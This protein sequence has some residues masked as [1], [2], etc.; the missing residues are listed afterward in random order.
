MGLIRG[1]H[2][3]RYADD[4]QLAMPWFGTTSPCR[5]A[6]AGYGA[7]THSFG[8]TGSKQHGDQLMSGL[9]R[10]GGSEPGATADSSTRQRSDAPGNAPP[11]RA[12]RDLE[13]RQAMASSRLRQPT[14]MPARRARTTAKDV[15]AALALPASGPASSQP[16]RPPLPNLHRLP[17][18]A[19]MVYDIG[20]VDTS[21]RIV[22]G[23]IV[24][25]L[26]WHAGDKLEVVLTQ[27]AIVIRFSPDGIFS[28]S[29]RPR[30]I[31]PAEAR[32]RHAIQPGDHVLLAAA[33]EFGIVIVYP[34]SAL[35]D[36]IARYH[37]T[38]PAV[39]G[40]EDE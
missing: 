37:S 31:I 20:R 33:P 26:R 32:R 36:M 30:I 14:T 9:I 16:T 21:G 19:S 4:V 40:D 38:Y 25:A 18:D 6:A 24:E 12:R 29:Q 7:R 34:L 11:V 28:L 15:M 1:Q 17:R 39:G 13:V 35:D 23:G 8:Q 5:Y 27:G 2:A 22:N 10:R 3:C